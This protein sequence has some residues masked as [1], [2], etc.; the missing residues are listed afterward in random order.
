M[1]AIQL[2]KSD[3]VGYRIDVEASSLIEPDEI[4]ERE[5][6]GTFMTAVTQFLQQAVP[7]V[8]ASPEAAPLFKGLLLWSVRGFRV[9]RDIEGLIEAGM[10]AM[11]NPA[12]KPPP[13]DPARDLIMA[14][15]EA[16]KQQMQIDGMEAQAKQQRDMEAHTAEM[17]EKLR[18]MQEKHTLELKAFQDK[19][20]AEVEAI[21][22]KAGV[23][24]QVIRQAAV[25]RA[26]AAG[27]EAASQV[28]RDDIMDSA[29]S[30]RDHETHL[31]SLSHAEDK[32]LQGLTAAEAKAM[33]DIDQTDAS[34]AQSLE[35]AAEQNLQGLAQADESHQQTLEQQE[36]AAKAALKNKPKE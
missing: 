6:R 8:Q 33:Q 20:Q 9:G 25:D 29:Q 36:E 26:E 31:Q 4:D 28:Q 30:A 12:P 2:L 18:Q 17:N 22:I 3:E 16:T 27:V 15:L 1:Q 10:D 34:N 19:S 32:A 23:Q 11:A 7:A 5:A 35:Q 24:S 14:K 13:P 21:L